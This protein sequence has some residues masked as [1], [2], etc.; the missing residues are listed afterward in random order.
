MS[1]SSSSPP[2][3]SKSTLTFI[4]SPYP[5]PCP[6]MAIHDCQNLSSK[7]LVFSVV[8]YFQ[9]M[10]PLPL[11][12]STLLTPKIST[13]SALFSSLPPS[14]LPPH[15]WPTLHTLSIPSLV[16]RPCTFVACSMKFRGNFVL[17]A[18][19]AQGLGTRLLRP[20]TPLHKTQVY[21][22]CTG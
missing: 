10:T 19:N 14:I 8:S 9:N 20:P 18:T 12:H 22:T 13:P 17:Q 6:A 2:P 4:S 1:F 3:P 11:R 15:P 21:L 5:S 7:S 16:P